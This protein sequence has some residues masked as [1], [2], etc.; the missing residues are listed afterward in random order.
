[1]ITENRASKYLLYAFGEII[2]VVIGILIALYLNN[3]QEVYSIQKQQENYL[4]QIKGE[5]ENNLKSLA[6]EEKDLSQKME[7][8]I[9]VLNI[10]SNDSL[11]DNLSETEISSLINGFLITDI[12]L[13][14]EDGALNQIIYSG[15]LKEIKNDS[16]SSLLAS[17]EGKINRVRLQEEQVAAGQEN[18]IHYVYQ[19]GNFRNLSDDLGYSKE[20]GIAMSEHKKGNKHLF[21]S[22]EYEN[23]IFQ[24]VGF[25]YSLQNREYPNFKKD[26][27]LL[28]TLI[29]KELKD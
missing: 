16:I 20:L 2:L 9:K 23:Y 18:L 17:W 8:A 4:R 10:M 6:I 3:K 1:M 14:Y 11:I 13:F 22:K 24:F 7:H 21:R 19:H 27:Q 5:M 15:G 26:I 28:I 29:D 12:V 25:G